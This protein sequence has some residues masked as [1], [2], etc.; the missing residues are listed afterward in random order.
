MKRMLLIL[1]FLFAT[2]ILQ[3]QIYLG[4]RDSQYVLG[5]FQSESGFYAEAEHSIYP[6]HLGYQKI[7]LYA[8]Y[9]HCWKT[10]S[11]DVKC[12]GSTLWNGYY[13]DFGMLAA[14]IFNPVACLSI[15][16]SLNP[17][18]DTGVGFHTNFSAGAGVRVHR[19]LSL[20]AHYSTI[21]EFRIPEKRIRVGMW[22]KVATIEVK[23]E[24]SIPADEKLKNVRV[25]FSMKYSFE[26]GCKSR[27]IYP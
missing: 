24:L 5:G 27:K 26:K 4:F 16:V 23:P 14:G 18:Y 15:D 11:A 7:R 3:A 22:F 10:I 1:A 21:P 17:H 6:E 13:Q 8:G 2:L 20:I 25:L 19:N 12:Y 9:N